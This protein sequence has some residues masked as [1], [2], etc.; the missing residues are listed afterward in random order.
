MAKPRGH[1]YINNDLTAKK[2]LGQH[3]LHDATICQRIVDAVALYKGTQ[4][5]EIGPG[6]G[7]ITKYLVEL[8]Y[9]FKCVE[10]DKEKVA[11]LNTTYPSLVGK[12]IEGDFLKQQEIFD[13]EFAIVGNFPYNISTEIVFKILDWK[14]QVPYVVGM[15]QK[16]VADRFA[17]KHGNKTYG[18]TS[19]L[20]QC[21]YDIDVLFDVPPTCFTPPPKVMSAVLHMH[22]NGNKY[23]IDNFK[24]FSKF[25]KIAFSQRRK[26]LR[27]CFKSYLNADVLQADIFG[28][29]AEQLSVQDFVDMYNTTF[30]S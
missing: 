18:V 11:Y 7:A 9:D 10:L 2:A 4:L 6:P 30:V 20:A 13:G 23:N 19:V 8:P 26:T 29:R 1:T 25:V 28:Q 5:L 16:E 14:A 12:I 17:S 3:F 21:Y 15:F 24:Q 27:N 22:Y